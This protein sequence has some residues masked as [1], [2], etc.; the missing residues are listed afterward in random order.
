MQKITDKKEKIRLLN[1]TFRGTF[2]TGIVRLTVGFKA[3]PDKEQ[4]EAITK[5]REFKD[6]TEDNDPYQEHDFGKVTVNS[7]DIF[8]KIDYHDKSLMY[9]SPDKSNPKVTKRVLTIMLA[10]EY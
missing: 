7:Q 6:F 4:E 3:L 2:I 10:E 9:H 8:W 1:D 5:I